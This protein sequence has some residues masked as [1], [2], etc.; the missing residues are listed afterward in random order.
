MITRLDGASARKISAGQVITDVASVVKEL[1]ENALDAESTVITIHLY[2]HGTEQIV[3]EDNGTGIDLSDLMDN[4]NGDSGAIR[5]A[6]S[7]PLLACRATTKLMS[8]HRAA[9]DSAAID[10][11]SVVHGRHGRHSYGEIHR[12]RDL[13]AR[14]GLLASHHDHDAC[15]SNDDSI[16]ASPAHH[17]A[18]VDNCED[19]A[20][21][22][23]PKPTHDDDA[24][25]ISVAT[26][27]TLGFRGEAL[28]SLAHVSDVTLSTMH[29][30]TAPRALQI[31]YD[32]TT[33]S[34]T[35]TLCPTHAHMGTTVTVH[36]LFRYLP[37]RRR[38]LMQ[39]GRKQLMRVVALV[40]Q[41]AVSHPHIRLVM[42]H[43][44]GAA[45]APVT[46]VSLT[47]SGDL[48]RSVCEAYGGLCLTRMQRV[49]WRGRFG[50]WVGLVSKPECYPATT[51]T[52]TTHVNRGRGGQSDNESGAAVRT[53]TQAGSVAV[54]HGGRMSADQQVFC[55][56]GRL[57]DL[58]RWAKAIQDAFIACLP[59]TA[60]RCFVA[61]FLQ[62]TAAADVVYDVNL[63]P[64]KRAVLLAK[65]E[66]VV[67]DLH[68]VA[69][70][71]FR[72]CMSEGEESV[73][74]GHADMRA[75]T[76]ADGMK[77]ETEREGECEG[78][79]WCSGNASQRDQ[80]ACCDENPPPP[81]PPRSRYVAHTSMSADAAMTEAR[82]HEV[83]RLARTPVSCTTFPE[84]V[85]RPSA[86][87]GGHDHQTHE[88][89]LSPQQ[90]PFSVRLPSR[91]HDSLPTSSCKEPTHTQ[92]RVENIQ[93]TASVKSRTILDKAASSLTLHW[94]REELYQRTDAHSAPCPR[95]VS[96]SSSS[97]SSSSCDSPTHAKS[98]L[99]MTGDAGAAANAAE[100]GKWRG[101]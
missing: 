12:T 5:E 81:P 89:S 57:V 21:S 83:R 48:Q 32:S 22:T 10:Y 31:H 50:E 72:S 60:R 75:D 23:W 74:Q 44:D 63:T 4:R 38:E 68:R 46:L 86:T 54:G 56:H 80:T 26:T 99:F 8:N 29:R 39:T 1:L 90:L 35:V 16:T 67:T 62:Y 96:Y 45:A 15:A 27:D 65:E 37:V 100:E 24:A 61:F 25:D 69:L 95:G 9:T 43:R 93:R 28:H 84:Y 92:T 47:G 33:E 55:F 71:H 3:V 19:V 14:H 94:L 97:V 77:K 49:H 41:Y 98:H 40:R 58:P 91:T 13:S 6:A 66:E 79:M 101:C 52:S 18:C 34:N 30:A 17:R 85:F 76:T 87:R 51:T 78:G 70:T 42:T 82:Y 53:R 64:S 7:T 88:H 73:N 11:S 2:A 59:D 36:Q 20:K